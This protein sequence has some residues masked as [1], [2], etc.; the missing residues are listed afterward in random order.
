VQVRLYG[1][2]FLTI[3]HQDYVVNAAQ[4]KGPVTAAQEARVQAVAGA[5]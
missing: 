1:K 5:K 3:D 2:K 4:K